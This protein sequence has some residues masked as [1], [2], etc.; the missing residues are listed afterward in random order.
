MSRPLPIVF[1][2][3]VSDSLKMAMIPVD[4]ALRLRD[5]AVQIGDWDSVASRVNIGTVLARWY[6][7]D[8]KPA[9]A[10]ASD[11]VAENKT[12]TVEQH[13][14]VETALHMVTDMEG[15]ITRRELSKAILFVFKA[16]GKK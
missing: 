7:P 12:F 1:R 14:I 9:M 13:A 2:H 4:C 8:A 5:G 6:F 15:K 10:E 16:A 11:I 3:S